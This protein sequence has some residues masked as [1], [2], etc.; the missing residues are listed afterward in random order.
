MTQQGQ[1]DRLAIR[2]TL[3]NIARAQA[4]AERLAL[5][6][7]FDASDDAKEVYASIAEVRHSLAIASDEANAALSRI[8]G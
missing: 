3:A 7:L 6:L 8:E 2:K 5:E 4:S 1:Q